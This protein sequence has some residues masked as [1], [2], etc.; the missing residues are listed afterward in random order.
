MFDFNRGMELL[1]SVDFQTQ[2]RGVRVVTYDKSFYNKQDKQDLQTV[3]DCIANTFIERGTRTTKKQLLS[4]K[5]KEVWTCECGKTNDIGA[6]CSGCSQDIY[7]FKANE[8][9]P[10]AA[11]NYIQQKI[12]L[13]SEF[14]D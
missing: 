14:V 11:D 7:G 2:K 4:S 1:Q 3:R 12:D 10:L 5:E 6:Y 8:V 9:K 13:I